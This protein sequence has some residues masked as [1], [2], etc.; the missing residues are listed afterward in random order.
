MTKPTSSASSNRRGAPLSVRKCLARHHR[1]A[2]SSFRQHHVVPHA[3][4]TKRLMASRGCAGSCLRAKDHAARSH[5]RL[6]AWRICAVPLHSTHEYRAGQGSRRAR[7]RRVYFRR[8]LTAPCQWQHFSLPILQVRTLS[9]RLGGRRRSLQWHMGH[10]ASRRWTDRWTGQRVRNGRKAPR[11]ECGGNRLP[12]GPSEIAVLADG[13][14]P[15]LSLLIS[16]P[17]L[18]HGP[19]HQVSC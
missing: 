18:E 8:C 5:R 17:K 3:T 10:R 2:V 11:A 9:I 15:S 4:G 13:G 6:R 14:N 7:G 1:R 19:H 12:A 16:S